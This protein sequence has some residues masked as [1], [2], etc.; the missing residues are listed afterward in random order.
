MSI[1]ALWQK[2]GSGQQALAA[3][4]EIKIKVSGLAGGGQSCI[5]RVYG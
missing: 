3:K 4:E 5:E 2:H 1:C